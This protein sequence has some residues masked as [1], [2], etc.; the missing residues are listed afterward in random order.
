MNSIRLTPTELEDWHRVCQI[1][2]LPVSQSAKLA[3][4]PALDKA[5]LTT[6][7]TLLT[8]S[9]GSEI[10]RTGAA[11]YLAR[12]HLAQSVQLALPDDLHFYMSEAGLAMTRYK[13]AIRRSD[14]DDDFN[15]VMEACRYLTLTE[16]GDLPPEDNIAS[17]LRTRRNNRKMTVVT[18]SPTAT[19]PDNLAE[20]L[21]TGKYISL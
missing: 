4:E 2:T 5:W 7:T 17:L 9:G 14:E 10:E 18:L 15:I 6:P 3:V 11:A 16:I 12:Y 1:P 13:V 21:K 8:I 20:V 19:I